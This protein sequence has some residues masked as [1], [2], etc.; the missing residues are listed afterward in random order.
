MGILWGEKNAYRFWLLLRW[1]LERNG[2]AWV[3]ELCSEFSSPLQIEV[4]EKVG[5]TQSNGRGRWVPAAG[6]LTDLNRS[7]TH[8]GSLEDQAD[9]GSYYCIHLILFFTFS[10]F[11]PFFL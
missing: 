4:M 7:S 6:Q 11:F 10:D 1:G 5:S 8:G 9:C 2:K 3:F